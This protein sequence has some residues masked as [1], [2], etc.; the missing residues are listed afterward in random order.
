MIYTFILVNES[1]LQWCS[2]AITDAHIELTTLRL[3]SGI[4]VPFFSTHWCQELACTHDTS[5]KSTINYEVGKSNSTF[6]QRIWKWIHMV[7]WT[8]NQVFLIIECISFHFL[9][10]IYLLPLNIILFIDDLHNNSFQT[11]EGRKRCL[12]SIL[13]I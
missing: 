11:S 10:Q 4:I 13:A 2:K 5:L 9:Y 8:G 3:C 7:D 1:W 12:R 6:S